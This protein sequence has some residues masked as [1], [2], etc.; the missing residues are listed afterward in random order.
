M[1]KAIRLKGST[2]QEKDTGHRIRDTVYGIRDTVY[3]ETRSPLESMES[4]LGPNRLSGP[5]YWPSSGVGEKKL[6]FT[7]LAISISGLV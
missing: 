7:R 5:L 4:L 6:R 3:G 2:E 1:T